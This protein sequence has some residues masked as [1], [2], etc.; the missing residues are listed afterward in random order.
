MILI[1]YRKLDDVS[2]DKFAN[3]TLEILTQYFEDLADSG[4]CDKDCDTT[5]AVSIQEVWYIAPCRFMETSH[6]LWRISAPS[7]VQCNQ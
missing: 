7:H 6:W 2:Y 5:F 1:V 3:S 4:L